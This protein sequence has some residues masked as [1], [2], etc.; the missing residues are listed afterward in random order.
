M[1]PFLIPLYNHV[2]TC[3]VLVK[4]LAHVI[5]NVLVGGGAFLD[6]L[7]VFKWNS[8][9]ST[10]PLLKKKKKKNQNFV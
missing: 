8:W 2:F 10:I 9:W 6:T 4:G 5:L 3:T 1:T 7:D